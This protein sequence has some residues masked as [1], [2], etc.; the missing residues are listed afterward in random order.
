[1]FLVFAFTSPDPPTLPFLEKIKGNPESC[2]GFSLRGTPKIL[3]KERKKR[4]K[5]AREIGKRKKQGNRKKQA[6]DKEGKSAINLSN[7]GNFCQIWPRAIY[8]C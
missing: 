3:G 8:L 2:K 7:L 6:L 4:T 5:Q 1:M